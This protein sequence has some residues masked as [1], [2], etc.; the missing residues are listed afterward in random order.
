MITK[1]DIGQTK[2]IICM[3]SKV[4][5]PYLKVKSAKFEC[6][7]CGTVLTVLQVDKKFREPT[8]CSCGRR[9]GF[10][11]ISKEL[12]EGQDITFLEKETNFEYKAYIEGQGIIDKLKA[13]EDAN[14]VTIKGEIQDEYKKNST[15]GEFV[16]FVEDIEQKKEEKPA[17][18]R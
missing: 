7:S 10:K 6:P 1:K 4:Q 18:L 14:F 12:I 11:V 9:G 8:R 15:Q 2:E 16:V 13:I 17:F 5:K 3:V